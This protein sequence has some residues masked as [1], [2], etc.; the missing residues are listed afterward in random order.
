MKRVGALVGA[1][2]LVVAAV[3]LRAVVFGD[4]DGSDSPGDD[5]GSRAG[6]LVCATDLADVCRAAGGDVATARAGTTAD[7]LI[8][9]TEVDALDG[10]AWIVPAAWARL[11]VA[12]RAR[13]GRAPLFEIGDPLASSPV[14]L[15]LWADR[16]DELAGR[17]ATV[18]WRCLAE[19]DGV[20]LAGGD[21]VQGGMPD[22]DTGGGLVVA[23][24][25]A[26]DLLDRTDYAAND[27]DGTFR[28]LAGR[29]AAGQAADPLTRMRGRGPGELTGAGVLAVDARNLAS[30]FG[31]I[32]PYPTDVR[33]DVVALV[34]AGRGFGGDARRA[35][36]EAF[37]DAGWSEPPDAPDGLPTGGVLAA[38]RTVW[39]QS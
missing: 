25:Q 8:A 34:P 2:A 39:N 3:V 17:C 15:A 5:G 12:E 32:E 21:R 9:A 38:I 18:D 13:L 1:V 23:A 29:L 14:V 31:T 33:V 24:A 7:A 11:V 30:T 6:G 35:L 27:F 26:A 36:V 10:D 20:A 19:Q 22:V 28:S 16:A 37:R 4:D